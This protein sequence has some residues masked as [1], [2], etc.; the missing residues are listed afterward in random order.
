MGTECVLL[1]WLV[2][3][4]SESGLVEKTA[5]RG[6]INVPRGSVKLKMN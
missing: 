6:K 5:R 2:Q 4:C 1:K 3:G